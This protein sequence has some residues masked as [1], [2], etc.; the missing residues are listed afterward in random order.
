MSRYLRFIDD[1]TNSLPDNFMESEGSD[2]ND[3]ERRY[4][5]EH[6]PIE[7]ITVPASEDEREDSGEDVPALTA[8][9]VS[10]KSGDEG[11]GDPEKEEPEKGEPRKGDQGADKEEVPNSE[12]EVDE[13]TQVCTGA[14]QDY[15]QIWDRLTLKWKTGCRIPL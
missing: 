5:R 7:I 3:Q 6:A 9:E 2:S 14:N 10:E 1:I 4:H 8:A 15:N 13:Y 11:D 12:D